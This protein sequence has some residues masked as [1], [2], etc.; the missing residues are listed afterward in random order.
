MVSTI[1]GMLVTHGTI[2]LNGDMGRAGAWAGMAVIMIHGSIHGLMAIMV[3]TMVHPIMAMLAGM[4]HAIIA[5]SIMAIPI[6][7]AAIT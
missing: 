6:M 2:A 1:H 4:A 7:V 3:A 5:H